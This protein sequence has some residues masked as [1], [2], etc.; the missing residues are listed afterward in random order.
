MT[1]IQKHADA[2]VV[3]IKGYQDTQ[4]I[5]LE[6]IDDGQGFEVNAHHTGFGLRGMQERVQILGGELEIKSTFGKGT[7]IRVLIPS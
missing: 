3:N 4:G 6:I 1:N 5:I 2:K 7:W